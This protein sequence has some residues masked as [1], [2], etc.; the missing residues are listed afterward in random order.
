MKL[1]R[2]KCCCGGNKSTPCVCM[3]KGVMECSNTSPKCPC[4]RL[5]DKQTGKNK[6][7]KHENKLYK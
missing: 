5:L 3:L 7:K 1:K 4:Y 6:V 2:E